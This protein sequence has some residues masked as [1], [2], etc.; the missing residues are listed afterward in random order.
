SRSHQRRAPAEQPSELSDQDDQRAGRTDRPGSTVAAL[1]AAGA[2]IVG[3]GQA[4]FEAAASLRAEGYQDPITLVGEERH[5]PYQRPP[6]S[7]GFVLDKQ[8]LDEIELRPKSFYRDHGIEVRVG[9]RAVHVN[10][11]KRHIRLAA[12]DCIP[13]DS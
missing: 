1:M 5:L 13:Y 6:L 2:V 11:E 3:A 12:G 7:K 4:G 8:G 9:E 10:R